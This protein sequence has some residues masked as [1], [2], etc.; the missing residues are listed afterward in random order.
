MKGRESSA[1]RICRPYIRKGE[2]LVLE[3]LNAPRLA[4]AQSSLR[5]FGKVAGEVIALD[6]GAGPSD[7]GVECAAPAVGRGVALHLLGQPL[8]GSG[9]G[10]VERARDDLPAGGILERVASGGVG[11]EERVSSAAS[12]EGDLARGI[13]RRVTLSEFRRRSA[14]RGYECE[15]PA[16]G[17]KL[18]RSSCE[19]GKRQDNR[20][21]PAECI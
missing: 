8:L 21:P 20:R 3:E 6:I 17:L 19:Q 13:T 10:E 15:A 16:R 4:E 12:A 9:R 14:R 7:L 5:W 2:L 18:G 11:M 1:G